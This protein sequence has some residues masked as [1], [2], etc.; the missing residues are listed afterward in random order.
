MNSR[1]QRP[2]KR[3]SPPRIVHAYAVTA[4]S[5]QGRTAPASVLYLARQTDAREIYVGL[6][7]HT[8][9]ARIVVESDRLEALCRQRQADHRTKPT[10]TAMRER[11]FAE[12]RQ[13]REKANVVDHCANRDEFLRTG[14]VAL[15]TPDT[16]AR[17]AMRA[18]LAA[19]KLARRAASPDA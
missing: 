17:L 14:L 2:G 18:V 1:R 9:D 12:A 7:R 16:P 6:T 15:P 3:K 13:Y 19:R 11:L 5:T 8:H 10:T 4:Y